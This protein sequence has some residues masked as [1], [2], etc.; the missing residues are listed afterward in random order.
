MGIM[1]L[2]KGPSSSRNTETMLLETIKT[3]QPMK[4][5]GLV[6]NPTPNVRIERALGRIHTLF[7]KLEEIDLRTRIDQL[8]PI[9]SKA[10]YAELKM[11]FNKYTA[12]L[13]S[14][15]I[16]IPQNRKEWLVLFNKYDIV[17]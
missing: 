15:D 12:T 1:K 4:K 8:D 6:I 7:M 16:D 14:H 5:T 3:G 11:S 17:R 13:R 10:K 9:T 2:F